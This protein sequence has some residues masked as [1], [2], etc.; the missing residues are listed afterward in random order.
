MSATGPM[1][2]YINVFQSK[3]FVAL[4]YIKLVI[5]RELEYMP[6]IDVNKAILLLVVC[7]LKSPRMKSLCISVYSSAEKSSFHIS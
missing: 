1:T 4:P 3:Y 5:L 6:L 7:M 2:E